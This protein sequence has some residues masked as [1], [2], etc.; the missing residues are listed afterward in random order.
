[1]WLRLACTQEY[2][3]L[4]LKHHN[5]RCALT[6]LAQQ[7]VC[8][9]VLQLYPYLDRRQ[10]GD[11]TGGGGDAPLPVRPQTAL[12]LKGTMQRVPVQ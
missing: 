7:C 11:V 1:M 12:L 3:A 9:G 4:P 8:V 5:D 6:K 2:A 10:L